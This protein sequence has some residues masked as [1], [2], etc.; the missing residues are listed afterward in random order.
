MAGRVELLMLAVVNAALLY[1]KSSAAGPPSSVEVEKSINPLVEAENCV[2]RTPRY[3]K[4]NP[5]FVKTE[6]LS[7][8]VKLVVLRQLEKEFPVPLIEL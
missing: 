4:S 1:P 3:Q 7:S 8:C 5:M 2:K 6:R